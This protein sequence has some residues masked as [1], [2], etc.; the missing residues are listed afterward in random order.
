VEA[1]LAMNRLGAAILMISKGTP[2]WQAGEEMLR[3]KDKGDGT[4]DENSYKSSD[5]I[6]NIKW[7]LLQPGTD[8]Y[9]MMLYYKGLI[10]MRQTYDIFRGREDVK[11][12]FG[13]LAG[14][15]MVVTYTGSDG[16]QAIVVINP[17]K[18]ADTYTL[19][20]EWKLVANGTKAGSEVIST[21]SG[22]VNVDA[23]SVLVYVK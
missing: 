20:G 10:E 1:R 6:N 2:F 4:F 13:T 11:I 8:A 17:T 3:S 7:D 12:S 9:E 14:G 21:D 23:C 16:S 18:T 5:A 15:G 19:S 22:T